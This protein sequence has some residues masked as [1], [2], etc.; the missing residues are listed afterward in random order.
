MN[1]ISVEGCR[2]CITI[3]NG[4][5]SL[6]MKKWKTTLIFLRNLMIA[7]YESESKT[8]SFNPLVEL[9]RLKPVLLVSTFDLAEKVE[10][11]VRNGLWR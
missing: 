4:L 8:C 1:D 9:L 11:L 3:R 5:F 2:F 7:L 6:F 10:L